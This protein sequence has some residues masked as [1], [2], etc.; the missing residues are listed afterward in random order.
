M[1]HTAKV[2]VVMPAYNAAKTLERTVRD[3]PSG[4]VDEIIVVDDASTD[5]TVTVAER[6]GLRVIVHSENR[7]YG[8]N[9][10]TCYDEAL[11]RGADIV[12]MIHA[13]YQYDSRLTPYIVGFLKEGICD[14][15]LGSRIRTRR[16]ALDG[17]M[18]LYK[19][20]SN[21]FLTIT[22]NIILGQNVSDFHTGFRAYTRHVLETIPYRLN[23]DSFV[24]DAEFLVQ[25]SYFG[26]RIGDIPVPARYFPE[27][28]SVDFKNSVIYGVQTLWT[29][30][31]YLAHTLG[32]KRSPLFRARSSKVGPF[33]QPL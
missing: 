27:A 33:H 12:V 17:G 30:V 13:D 28:S 14:V 26:S 24:F 15:M 23:S 29:L 8:A 10:K 25:A 6:L 5:E 32:I 9:Q 2:V 20:L 16:E 18:P 31:R 7:G 19:Y 11:R 21:R 1:A 4:C 3:I 22:E